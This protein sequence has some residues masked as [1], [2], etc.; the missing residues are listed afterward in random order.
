MARFT[1]SWERL[2]RWSR[3]WGSPPPRTHPSALSSP[4]TSPCTRAS[5]PVPWRRCI[6]AP[7]AGVVEARAQCTTLPRGSSQ[8]A[9]RLPQYTLPHFLSDLRISPSSVSSSSSLHYQTPGDAHGD[10]GFWAGH[11]PEA[12]RGSAS[13]LERAIACT[14]QQTLAPVRLIQTTERALQGFSWGEKLQ[15]PCQPFFF[16]K[17][18][19]VQAKCPSCSTRQT[20]WPAGRG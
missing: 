20:A 17:I 5:L 12:G 11:T 18:S 15:F 19:P 4:G 7:M 1:S 3:A 10:V 9:T 13:V 16:L 6:A 8:G 2:A 14:T